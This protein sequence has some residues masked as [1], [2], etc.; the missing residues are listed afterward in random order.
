MQNK[1]EHTLCPRKLIPYLVSY[2]I[3]SI[4]PNLWGLNFENFEKITHSS[5]SSSSSTILSLQKKK[6][7][8]RKK[9]ASNVT[10]LWRCMFVQNRIKMHECMTIKSEGYCTVRLPAQNLLVGTQVSPQSPLSQVAQIFFLS[11]IV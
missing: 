6:K 8:K 2:L 9:A 1:W 3:F 7:K 5:S 11:W 10:C 4:L